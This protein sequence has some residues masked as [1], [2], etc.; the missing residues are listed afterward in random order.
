MT[1]IKANS[2]YIL[3]AVIAII[4][5]ILLKCCIGYNSATQLLVKQS[6]FGTMSCIDHAGF[7]FK[8]FASIYSYDRTKDFY[9][10]SSSEKDGTVRPSDK[11]S[12]QGHP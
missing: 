2:K 3:F 1:N 4:V 7:Y 5:L 10:N 8:G 11:G 6:P 12:H 9:F